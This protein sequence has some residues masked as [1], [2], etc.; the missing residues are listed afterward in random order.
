MEEKQKVVAYIS[1]TSRVQ[2][3]LGLKMMVFPNKDFEGYKPIVVNKEDIYEE[4]GSHYLRAGS[5]M[6]PYEDE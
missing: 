2:F 4:N 6:S 3:S 5:E 1:D